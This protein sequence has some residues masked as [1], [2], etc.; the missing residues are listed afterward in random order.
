MTSVVIEKPYVGVSPAIAL[1]IAETMGAIEVL[2]SAAWPKAHIYRLTPSEWRKRCGL[3]GR[4]TK[5]EVTERAKQIGFTPENQDAADAG[6][7]AWAGAL[8]QASPGA[9]QGK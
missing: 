3:S 4:A 5:A 2:S 6:L 9:R 7:M 8:G 1:A